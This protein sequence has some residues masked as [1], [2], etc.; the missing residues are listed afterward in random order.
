MPAWYA[1]MG[2]TGAQGALGD[3]HF[4]AQAQGFGTLPG[5]QEGSV[6]LA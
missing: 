2:V 3:P 5:L 1:A 4:G 6:R